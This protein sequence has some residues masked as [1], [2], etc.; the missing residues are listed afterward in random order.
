MEQWLPLRFMVYAVDFGT[1]NTVVVRWNLA[2]QQPETVSLPGL[3]Q[4]LGQNPPLIPSL[5]YVENAAEGK[6]L[7]GQTV[8]DRGFDLSSDPRFFR[9]FKRG[10]W[11]RYPGLFT[12]LRWGEQL[13]LNRQGNGF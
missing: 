5:V 11:C 9:N 3:S 12:R 8:R 6:V 1:S 2:T 13:P 10:Y 7:A 4:R